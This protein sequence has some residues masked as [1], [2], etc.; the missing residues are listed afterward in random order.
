MA[1]VNVKEPKTT[2]RTVNP[3]GG[4]A[5]RPEMKTELMLRTMSFMMAGDAY[6]TKE[7][8]TTARVDELVEM[9]SRKDPLYVLK[10]AA[11][12]RNEMHMRSI[13]IHL[14]VRYSMLGLRK[15]GAFMWVPYILKRADEPGECLAEY[16]Q[17]AG[18]PK[19]KAHPP[20]PAMLKKGIG[21]TM[22]R[23][24]EY[25]LA[26]YNREGKVTLKDV[27]FLTHPKPL[28]LGQNK[29]NQQVLFDKIVKG[30]LATPNTW[31]VVISTKG[32]TKENW[33]AVIPVMGYMALLRNLRNFLEKKVDM[34]PVYERLTDPKAVAKSKQ[35]PYRFLSAMKELESHG[36]KIVEKLNTALKL[37]V[38]NVPEFKGKTAVFSDNS[39][40]MS[41]AFASGRSKMSYI[42]IAGLFSAIA[43]ERCDDAYVGVFGQTFAW[44]KGLSNCNPLS[45]AERIHRTDVGHSTEGWMA[46]KALRNEKKFVDRIFIFSDM[47]L[48]RTGSKS[49]NDLWFQIR[50]YRSE[51]NPDCRLYCF[52]LAGEGLLKVPESDNL[53]CTVAG[54]S[55]KIY[56]FAAMWEKG[57]NVMVN[58]IEGYSPE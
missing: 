35:F 53:T 9:I 13:P 52:D 6:Y 25:Q 22:N 1:R 32:S 33:E 19:N 49:E 48:Y 18:I 28:A 54:W 47:Q 24:D 15:K 38:A 42:E 3:A 51:I 23:F 41:S 39:G 37:S 17:L 27:V 57:E 12:A 5:F 16:I 40:S 31:E 58:A 21:L 11:F 55:D 56:T 46:V 2:G 44:V 34:D 36:T 43:L 29:I 50:K 8:D 4:E 7:K 20:I 30:E 14:L 10:L 26:K 45:S